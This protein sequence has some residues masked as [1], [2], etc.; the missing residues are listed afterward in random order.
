MFHSTTNITM[1]M[2]ASL[3]I[4]DNAHGPIIMQL[5]VS[6]FSTI[7]CLQMGV[8]MWYF[9]SLAYPILNNPWRQQCI[10]NVFSV[11]LQQSFI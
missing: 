10:C 4:V 8:E 11:S 6:G 1:P 7:K 3:F 2:I 9:P 5:S